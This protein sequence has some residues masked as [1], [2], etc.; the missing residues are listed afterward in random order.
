MP[1]VPSSIEASPRITSSS[2]TGA[3]PKWGT[4]LFKG[5]AQQNIENWHLFALSCSQVGQAASSRAGP[6]SPSSIVHRPSK[7]RESSCLF[8][9]ETKAGH[10]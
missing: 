5:S 2:S 6:P 3:A 10:L 7:F 1:F 8:R 4:S 9:C